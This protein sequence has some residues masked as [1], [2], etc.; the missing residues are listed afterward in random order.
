[1]DPYFEMRD[2]LC[3]ALGK[4]YLMY[5]VEVPAILAR[6]AG[7]NAPAS[8]THSSAVVSSRL[9]EVH[10]RIEAE[11]EAS[12]D[13]LELLDEM[14]ARVR[15]QTV[16][17]G[18]AVIEERQQ[19]V[20]SAHRC[21]GEEIARFADDLRKVGAEMRSGRP[22]RS[23]KFVARHYKESKGA[24]LSETRSV[25]QGA[26]G[27]KPTAPMLPPVNWD[28]LIREEDDHS[29]IDIHEAPVERVTSSS[30]TKKPKGEE[31][32]PPPDLLDND[33]FV[34]RQQQLMDSETNEQDELL[35]RL[36]DGV[37]RVRE[38]AINIGDEVR[39][40]GTIFDRISTDVERT[41]EKLGSVNA[42][43]NVI[44]ENMSNCKKVMVI[45]LLSGILIL[46]F[47]LLGS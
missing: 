16:E 19:F 6:C 33:A 8:S 40:Q 3:D 7:G 25:L 13:L 24:T 12:N 39:S 22:V 37:R 28:L 27:A 11:V 42:R 36:G 17:G 5:A 23:S 44:I 46:L 34:L 1:M 29:T 2:E 30:D 20:N 26:N 14:L 41:M 45:F 43:I 9:D 38:H 21:I 32:S 18:M 4:C 35:D 31:F 15:P 47:S 10:V